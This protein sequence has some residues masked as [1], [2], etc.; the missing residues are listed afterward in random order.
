MITIAQVI[1]AK[2]VLKE[3]YSKESDIKSDSQISLNK[4]RIAY[5][6]KQSELDTWKSVE[7]SKIVKERDT[8][9]FGLKILK[10]EPGVVYEEYKRLMELFWI[11]DTEVKLGVVRVYKGSVNFEPY[12]E[13][14]SSMFL[15]IRPYIVPNGKPVKKYSLILEA[16]SQSQVI[17]L[18]SLQYSIWRLSYQL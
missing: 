4:I 14:V 18:S 9:L 13:L 17:S 11:I 7:D 5:L 3:L 2:R 16:H 1:E 15:N 8:E 10:K 6:D 12:D